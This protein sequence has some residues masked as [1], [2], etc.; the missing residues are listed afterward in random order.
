LR[1]RFMELERRLQKPTVPEMEA[2]R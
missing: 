1:N 2:A